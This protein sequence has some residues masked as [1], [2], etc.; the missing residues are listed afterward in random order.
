MQVR[1]TPT[2]LEEHLVAIKF[3]RQKNPKAAWDYLE[4]VEKVLEQL[5]LFP[6]SGRSIPEYPNTGYQ[7]VIIPPNRYI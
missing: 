6:N 1:F 4:H 5:K 7:E 2:A 3:I